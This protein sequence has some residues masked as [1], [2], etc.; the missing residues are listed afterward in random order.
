MVGHILKRQFEFKQILISPLL[1]TSVCLFTTTMASVE[2]NVRNA[3]ENCMTGIDED[4]IEYLQSLIM[5]C[6]IKDK[7]QLAETVVPFMEGFIAEGDSADHLFDIF[8]AQLLELNAPQEDADAV[9]DVGVVAKLKQPVIAVNV[10]SAEDQAACDTLWG[11]DSIRS[12]KNDTMEVS[13][14]ASAKYERRA[15]KEQRQW[16][17]DIENQYIG[18]EEDNTQIVNMIIPTYLENNKECDIHVRNVVINFSGKLLLEDAELRIVYGKRYGL[19]GRNGVGKTTLLKKMA[20]F[21]ID[22]F[23][24]HHRVLHVKQEVAASEATVLE[25]VLSAD[26]E[27][28]SLLAREKELIRRQ[29]NLLGSDGAQD[30]GAG[31]DELDEITQELSDVYQRMEIT[32]VR[33]AESRIGAILSGLQFT[34]EMQRKTTAEL[35]GGWRMRVS[36]AAA[37]FIKP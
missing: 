5:Q 18:E 11:F 26:V 27:R 6:G 35:S 20:N 37:L 33:S 4:T 17:N 31:G 10:L 28:T 8:Y 15:E 16:L 9:R 22:G 23:P 24:K 3:I 25:A 21:S 36:L 2:D 13:E 12:K 29:E 32:G 1:H 34:E 19:V 30:T 14:A 7:D